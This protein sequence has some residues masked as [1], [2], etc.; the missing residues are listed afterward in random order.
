MTEDQYKVMAQYAQQLAE[1][2]KA[3]NDQQLLDWCQMVLDTCVAD[4][5]DGP[6]DSA[7]EPP[8]DPP[9]SDLTLSQKLALFPILT[10][11]QTSA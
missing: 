3:Y 6:F 5:K 9:L 4:L 10:A 8:P 2:R 1:M 11:P 7:E